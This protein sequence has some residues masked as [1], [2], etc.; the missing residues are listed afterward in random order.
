MG[1]VT[2]E[3]MIERLKTFYGEW[4]ISDVTDKGARGLLVRDADGHT[5]IV[6]V[7]HVPGVVVPT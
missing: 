5:F 4:V 3:V 1:E 7:R 6:S 2:P